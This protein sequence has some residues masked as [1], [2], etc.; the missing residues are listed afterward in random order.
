MWY[1]QSQLGD[2]GKCVVQEFIQRCEKLGLIGQMHYCSNSKY[3][4][5]QV[6][7]CIGGPRT[8]QNHKQ[9]VFAVP[10]G[11]QV[12]RHLEAI[13]GCGLGTQKRSLISRHIRKHA[14][15]TEPR[16]WVKPLTEEHVWI[17][18]GTLIF[19]GMPEQLFSGSCWRRVFSNCCARVVTMGHHQFML[20]INCL[21][22]ETE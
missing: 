7:Q 17:R 5:T 1:R 21:F 13:W 14:D 16:F 15:G 19:S 11:S 22:V 12:V 20:K 9:F 18:T 3:L 6:Y 2:R 8:S 4:S 10:V